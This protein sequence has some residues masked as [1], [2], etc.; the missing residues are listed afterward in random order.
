MKMSVLR[1]ILSKIIWWLFKK[2]CGGVNYDESGYTESLPECEVVLGERDVLLEIIKR[3]DKVMLEKRVFLNPDLTLDS[4]AKEVWSNRTY[5]SRAISRKKGE[6]F[7]QYVNCYRL[8][9]AAE[10]CA[11]KRYGVQDIA[12]ASGFRSARMFYAALQECDSLALD[13][14]KKSYLY[15]NFK[16]MAD[17]KIIFSMN[18]VGKILPSNNKVILKDIYLSFFYGAKIGI[19]GLNGSGK[20]ILP[21]PAQV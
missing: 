7:K 1:I 5:L 20:S 18:G 3:A 11:S 19:I 4:L 2:V 8:N 15:K 16:D 9:Y 14:L 10:L 12:I 6:T 21:L 17:E 13:Y